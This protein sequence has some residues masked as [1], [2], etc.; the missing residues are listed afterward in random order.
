MMR[1]DVPVRVVINEY[2]EVANA[3]Y[4]G[5]EPGMVNG[6][7]DAIAHKTRPEEFEGKGR[8]HAPRQN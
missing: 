3:F 6:V 8:K 2:V 7:L 1:R 4:E 5:E